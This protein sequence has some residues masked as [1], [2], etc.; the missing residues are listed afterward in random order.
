LAEEKETVFRQGRRRP[1]GAPL[2][3][4]NSHY[5]PAPCEQVEDQYY[6]SNDQQ[7]MNQSASDMKAEA[8]KPKNDKNYEYHPKHG[9]S[10]PASRT[11]LA[12]PRPARIR[13]M[14]CLFSP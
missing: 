6:Y 11:R 12:F 14:N 10:P 5:T 7:K 8:E 1:D 2:I 13:E 3:V 9:Q 4:P